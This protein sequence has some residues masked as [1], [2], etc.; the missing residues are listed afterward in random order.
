MMAGP[1]FDNLIYPII[2]GVLP[3]G[4]IFGQTWNN[5]GY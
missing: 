4:D 1:V 5:T 3:Y 2:T